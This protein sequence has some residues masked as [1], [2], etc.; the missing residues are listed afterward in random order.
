M[1]KF[2]RPVGYDFDIYVT[3]TIYCYYYYYYCKFSVDIFSVLFSVEMTGELSEH[4]LYHSDC[5]CGFDVQAKRYFL[6]I[7]YLCIYTIH[8]Y[9]NDIR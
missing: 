5:A 3:K 2:R 1:T 7:Q 6:R 4:K 8:L 9:I